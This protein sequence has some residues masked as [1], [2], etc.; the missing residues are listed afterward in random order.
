MFQATNKLKKIH[1][2]WKNKKYK[3][4]QDLKRKKQIELKMLADHL[5]KGIKPI[6]VVFILFPSLIF[7]AC[8]IETMYRLISD[9]KCNYECNARCLFLNERLNS[10]EKYL[11]M[12]FMRTINEKYVVRI[13]YL[14]V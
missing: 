9:K 6:V 2:I 8:L 11:K 1:T 3:I 4:S 5:F 14:Y 10:L 13:I 7:I 12:S